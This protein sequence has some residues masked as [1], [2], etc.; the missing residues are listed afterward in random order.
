MS[1]PQDAPCWLCY[2]CYGPTDD[3]LP[4]SSFL[5]AAQ[6]DARN[7]T[8]VVYVPMDDKAWARIHGLNPEPDIND[9]DDIA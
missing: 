5:T 3:I 9:E 1:Q 6:M 4:D 8:E 7:D 2:D